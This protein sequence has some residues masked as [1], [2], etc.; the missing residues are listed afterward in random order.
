MTIFDTE[1]KSIYV[2]YYGYMYRCYKYKGKL[3]GN[4]AYVNT[5]WEAIKFILE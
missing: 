1:I 3:L 2:P 5:L 4:V